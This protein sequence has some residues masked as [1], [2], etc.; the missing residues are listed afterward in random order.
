[1]WEWDYNESWAPK[2]LCFWTMVLEKTLESP[3]DSKEIEPVHPKGD[4]SW[5]FIGR[6]DFAAETLVLWPPDVKSYLVWKD[7]D[8]GK[9]W[10]Q[11]CCEHWCPNTSL[12]PYFEFIWLYIQEWNYGWWDNSVLIL[13]AISILFAL[14]LMKGI[15]TVY[16][17]LTQGWV[18][19][20][21]S[22]FMF[23]YFL[24]IV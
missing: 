22:Q 16:S 3:L 9:Y 2:N 11:E 19:C 13:E 7:P 6:T 20:L 18:S 14:V 4:K 1:M 21:E 24:K 12:R 10:G 23:Y 8:A 5:V 15:P 17:T